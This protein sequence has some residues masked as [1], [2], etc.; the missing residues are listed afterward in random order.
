MTILSRFGFSPP[1]LPPAHAR[2]AFTL[3]E[4]TLAAGLGALV[5][6]VTM[7]VFVQIDRT[8]SL[9]ARRADDANQLANLRLVA[10]RMVST[11]VMSSDPLPPKAEGE[12]FGSAAAGRAGRDPAAPLPFPRLLVEFDPRLRGTT[13]STDGNGEWKPDS[14]PIQRFEVVL[15]DAPVPEAGFDL[16]DRARRNSTG[17]TSSKW[18]VRGDIGAAAQPSNSSGSS[19]PGSGKGTPGSAKD[20]SSPVS[21]KSSVLSGA[22]AGDNPKPRSGTPGQKSGGSKDGDSSRDDRQPDAATGLSEEELTPVRAVRGSLALRPQPLTPREA[23]ER[24]TRG[25]VDASGQPRSYAWEVWWLP[26]PPRALGSIDPT[27]SEMV[28]AGEPYLVAQNITFMKWE[29]YDDD[30]E[31]TEM[32]ATWQQQLPAYVRLTVETA[33]G[34]TS[35]W[36]F[37][38]NWGRGPEVPQQAATPGPA[39]AKP[40]GEAGQTPEKSAQPAQPAARGGPPR[41]SPRSINKGKEN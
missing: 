10:Q 18:W 19:S 23:R 24:Q 32:K 27:D 25:E 1:I 39:R 26:L 9:L 12:T 2:R 35:K 40:V 7:G 20:N 21:G 15:T 29:L 30:L 38:V 11:L 8:E 22:A 13:L 33:S 41:L 37:E 36:M 4:V 16:F 14:T 34:M 6:L 28:T 5:V 31:R 3:L 17:R